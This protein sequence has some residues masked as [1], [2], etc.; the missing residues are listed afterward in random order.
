MT[1]NEPPK[2]HA[3]Y[4]AERPR[5]GCTRPGA[6]MRK[7]PSMPNQTVS[8]RRIHTPEQERLLEQME[9]LAGE[10]NAELLDIAARTAKTRRL[11]EA[12]E[13]ACQGRLWAA[14]NTELEYEHLIESAFDRFQS[15]LMDSAEAISKNIPWLKV[16]W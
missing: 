9:Q 10:L 11:W 8:P 4:I 12:F 15:E 5:T 2:P 7:G 3:P 6:D 1:I 13:S 14:A 16:D